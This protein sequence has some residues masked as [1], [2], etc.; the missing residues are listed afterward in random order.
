M[1][2]GLHYKS[3]VRLWLHTELWAQSVGQGQC[4]QFFHKVAC[5]GR[6]QIHAQGQELGVALDRPERLVQ[7]EPE[8][9]FRVAACRA[10][11]HAQPHVAAV[12]RLPLLRIPAA[13]DLV[14]VG[15]S[16]VSIAGCWGCVTA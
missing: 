3:I 13:V 12:Q 7:Q 1:S 9:G 10:V 8:R 14:L 15:I 5:S 2:A 6:L 4:L 16:R 11:H